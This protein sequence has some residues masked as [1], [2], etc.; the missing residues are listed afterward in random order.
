MDGHDTQPIV[1]GDG[2]NESSML[3]LTSPALEARNEFAKHDSLSTTE[4]IKEEAAILTTSGIPA[5]LA[6]FLQYSFSFVNIMSLG[7]LGTVELA[8]AAL[9]NM[10]VFMV[11]NAPGLGL[12]S[13]LDTF[14]P[15]AFTGS[16]DRT[17]VG[18]HLQR[19]II[20]VTI[21]FFVVLPVLLN[22]ESIF[23]FLRQDPEISHLSSRFIHVQL[24]G[25][26]PWLY[27]EC[28]RC[29]LQAQRHMKANTY[30]LLAALP[31][32][33]ANTYLFVWS[34]TFGIGFIGAAVSNVLTLWAALFGIIVYCRF[35]DAKAAW[36]GW[37]RHAFAT[38][39]DYYRL[40][41]PSVV[42]VC[43]DWV[44][45]EMMAITSSYL[46]NVVL[47]AQSIAINTCPL[48]Y[49]GA[50]GL[51]SAISS[52]A[53]NLLGQSRARRAKI[54]SIVGISLGTVWGAVIG[55]LYFVVAGWWGRVYTDDAD[56]IATVALIMPYCSIFQFM[57]AISC[58]SGGVLRSFGRQGDSARIIFVSYYIIG[59]PLG[60]YLTYGRPEMGVL[61]LWI[62]ISFGA[63]ITDIRH[64]AICLRA[65]YAEEVEKCRAQVNRSEYAAARDGSCS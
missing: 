33:L 40:A 5:A 56:V 17:L 58:V 49:Q 50:N 22:I 41:I 44:A 28:I 12:A 21:H 47:A 64:T 27:F 45:W 15:T 35:T 46:G 25:A 38:L 48:T 18:F 1:N 39:P 36:G 2:V 29:F 19:G 31:L 62:G 24:L 13:A 51:R 32:H 63:F 52:R 16:R 9:A 55:M 26:I 65:N 34:Q 20:S 61:G 3:L 37:S 8:A 60:L 6:F 42:M 7:H 59:I 10:T 54:S 11:V 53:G 23:I 43:S 14:C 4:I 57:D 30:V